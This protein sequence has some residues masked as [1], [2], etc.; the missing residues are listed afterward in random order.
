ML[1]ELVVSPSI[2][3]LSVC[4][5]WPHPEPVGLFIEQH[6]QDFFQRDAS[7]WVMGR[8]ELGSGDGQ[9]AEVNVRSLH[10]A[11]ATR[12]VVVREE[13]LAL[14]VMNGVIVVDRPHLPRP[15]LRVFR[16][17]DELITLAQREAESGK[18]RPSLQPHRLAFSEHERVGYLC[19]SLW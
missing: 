10:L 16:E 7:G 6:P 19:R 4:T 8:L 15:A 11:P 5:E 14:V 1:P 17:M 3:S 2:V 9:G 18:A 12:M 13:L